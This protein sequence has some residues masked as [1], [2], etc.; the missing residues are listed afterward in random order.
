MSSILIRNGKIAIWRDYW[1]LAILMKH[2]LDGP[3]C[4]QA[5]NAWEHYQDDVKQRGAP[6]RPIDY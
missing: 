2:M 3:T 4:Q 1:D 5:T 6:I